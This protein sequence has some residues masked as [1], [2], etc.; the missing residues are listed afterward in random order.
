MDDIDRFEQAYRCQPADTVRVGSATWI[1]VAHAS[2]DQVVL[3]VDNAGVE[4]VVIIDL[5]EAANGQTSVKFRGTDAML[6]L[7]SQNDFP[8][9]NDGRGTL[10]YLLLGDLVELLEEG[11]DEENRR[12]LLV[13][14]DGLLDAIPT[15]GRK[16]RIAGVRGILPRSQHLQNRLT[17]LELEHDELMSQLR[18]LRNRVAWRLSLLDEVAAE[19][20]RDLQTWLDSFMA[21]CNREA[22]L[23]RQAVAH[24]D[25]VANGALPSTADLPIG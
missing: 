2:T 24:L 15:E 23:E 25:A 9:D 8:P 16:G 22:R 13:V 19:V 21:F 14:L 10:E 5:H 6:D 3:E 20:C 18:R 17:R 4:S 7:N 11:Y 12:W 1:R